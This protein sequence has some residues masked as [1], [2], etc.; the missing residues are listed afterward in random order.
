MKPNF[1]NQSP[2]IDTSKIKATK[3][4]VLEFIRLV[5]QEISSAFLTIQES[6]VYDVNAH[7]IP[8][9]VS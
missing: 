4:P 1:R 9:G 8:V 6:G 2:D 5:T 7:F 3:D